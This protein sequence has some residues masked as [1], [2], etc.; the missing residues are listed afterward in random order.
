MTALA[1]Q[2]QLNL[3]DARADVEHQRGFDVSRQFNG[4][5][6]LVRVRAVIEAD[7]AGGKPW[8][9]RQALIDLASAATEMAARL[10]RPRRYGFD[11]EDR[12]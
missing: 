6:L 7:A 3:A 12:S 1:D 4:R 10:P 9:K 2:L 5:D 8:A 11:S